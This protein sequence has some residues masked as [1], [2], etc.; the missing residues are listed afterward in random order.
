MSNTNGSGRTYSGTYTVIGCKRRAM[1]GTAS[2]RRWCGSRSERENQKRTRMACE[3]CTPTREMSK[4]QPLFCTPE[5][6]W[7]GTCETGMRK[8]MAH[9][10]QHQMSRP[11]MGTLR[12]GSMALRLAG[13]ANEWKGTKKMRGAS[14]WRRQ[15]DTG[16]HQID[17]SGKQRSG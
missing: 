13:V 12:S 9:R 11:V 6:S 3:A 15:Q 5:G 4:R 1:S 7:A 8:Q 16:V 10:E 17:R 2:K 14:V